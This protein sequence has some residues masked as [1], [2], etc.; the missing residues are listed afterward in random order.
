MI[1]STKEDLIKILVRQRCRLAALLADSDSVRTV[2][3]E[4]PKVTKEDI[5]AYEGEL[6]QK[7]LEQLRAL[8]RE[9]QEKDRHARRE[10]EESRY[11]YNQPD[12]NADFD[13]WSK[14]ALWTLDE[15]IALCLGKEPEVVTWQRLKHII[16]MSPF[17]T[18]YARYRELARRA[19]SQRQLQ[20]PAEPLSFLAWAKKIELEIADGLVEQVERRG[21]VVRDWKKECEALTG[22]L[23]KLRQEQ[24][25]TTKASETEQALMKFSYWRKFSQMAAKA[26]TEYPLWH[27]HQRVVHKSG[28]L[29]EWLTAT[30]G[31]NSREAEIIK[32]LLSEAYKDLR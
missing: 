20:D 9:A 7:P 6:Q 2:G 16:K 4:C 27:P 26:I 14:S 17:A 1:R 3:Y 24:Q 22:E 15:A 10:I 8:H 19:V 25:Q 18:K 12:A 31:A 23:E 29:Q 21:P 32:K 30:I 28:N 5:A 11:F 13:Y